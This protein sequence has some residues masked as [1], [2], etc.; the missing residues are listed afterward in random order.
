[1]NPFEP[2]KTESGGL[3]TEPLVQKAR[4]PFRILALVVGVLVIA[5]SL[6]TLQTFFGTQYF[7][8]F[9]IDS[10]LGL[11]FGIY[12]CWLAATGGSIRST[13]GDS[14]ENVGTDD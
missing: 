3:K 8:Q 2:P 5:S 13:P 1:M 10:A 12:M 6:T 14:R 7:G 4:V 9:W 11:A